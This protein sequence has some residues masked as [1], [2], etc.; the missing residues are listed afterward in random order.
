MIVSIPELA[1]GVLYA[2]RSL[3]G[4]FASVSGTIG[5]VFRAA[6]LPFKV[7]AGFAM[8]FFRYSVFKQIIF[9]RPTHVKTPLAGLRVIP[10]GHSR[11]RAIVAETFNM[12]I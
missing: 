8:N 6:V 4:P 11:L 7:L 12:L 10:S 1:F 9:I 3:A 5:F 2:M